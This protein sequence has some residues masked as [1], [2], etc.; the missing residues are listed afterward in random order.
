MKKLI[1]LLIV[2][3]LPLA[4]CAGHDDPADQPKE[5]M[6]I[7]V[8]AGP[9]GVGMANLMHKNEAGAACEYT[10]TVCTGP[11]E[12]AAMIVSGE[13]DAAAVPSNL[14]AVLYQK[15]NKA[16]Q[17][18]AAGTK[19][20]LYLLENG[21]TIDAL[22]DLRGKTVSSIGEGANPEYILRYLLTQNGLDPDRDVTLN[23]VSGT[24]E[25]TALLLD[26]AAEIALVPEPVV[27]VVRS[28]NPDLR[29]AV[30]I[31]DAW[32]ALDAGPLLMTGII[33]RQEYI[34]QH[35][36][37]IYMFLKEYQESVDSAA[38]SHTAEYCEKYGI[39]PTAALAAA[40]IPRC[41]VAYI[42]GP[43]MKAQ[44]QGYLQVLF[45]A[46][47]KAVGGGMPD[48]GFYYLK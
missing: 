22:T 39:I 38:D 14:A 4:G 29:V 44:I 33:A 18:L 21:D 31:G 42:D 10:F 34:D 23:F 3:L 36:Q 46:D 15:T 35:P 24:D 47:P 6:S 8:I 45:D 27:S 48:D 2:V 1:I 37:A 9:S 40:A 41:N 5:K 30:S 13:A 20:V 17:L 11:D 26:G 16:L 7:A 12:A 19:G 32:D 25:L 43:E 28:K